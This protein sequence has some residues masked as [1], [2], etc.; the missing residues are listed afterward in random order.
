MFSFYHTRI[1]SHTTTAHMWTMWSLLF[2]PEVFLLC[3]RACSRVCAPGA[4]QGHCRGTA[5]ALLGQCVVCVWG[6]AGAVRG[7]CAVARSGYVHG[8]VLCKDAQHVFASARVCVW[9]DP[10]VL[11]MWV[12]VRCSVIPAVTDT[13]FCVQYVHSES[14]HVW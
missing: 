14:L 10:T 13:V 5:G 8:C 2:F 6:S 12:R 7:H 9:G 1:H 11:S 4:L 3:A